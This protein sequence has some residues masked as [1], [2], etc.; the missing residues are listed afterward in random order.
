MQLHEL[1][2]AIS[3]LIPYNYSTIKSPHYEDLIQKA[4]CG[5]YPTP[6]PL[7]VQIGGIPG[8]GKST[9]CHQHLPSCA[10]YIS[11]DAIMENLPAYQKDLAQLGNL[12]AFNKWEI[13][14]RVIGY[15][16]LRR[17]IVHKLNIFMEHSGANPAHLELVENIKKLNYRTEINYILCNEKIAY[18]RVQARE[19]ITKRHTPEKYI[20]ERAAQIKEYLDKYRTK[21]D[22]FFVYDSSD[23]QFQL[24]SRHFKEL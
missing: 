21:V 5:F 4:V 14:A 8:S 2:P 20:T 7:F 15:E 24:K 13:P 19:K 18:Q 23:N 22:K 9:F 3:K 6:Q 11:F 16:V 17:C 12:E 1:M 10:V